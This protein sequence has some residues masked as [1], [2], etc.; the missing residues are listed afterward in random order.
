M[1]SAALK[2][3][4]PLIGVGLFILAAMVLYRQLKTYQLPDILRQVHAIPSGQIPSALLLMVISY[5]A[6]IGYDLPALRYI[7]H[8]LH[9]AKAAL[10]SLLGYAFSNSLGPTTKSAEIAVSGWAPIKECPASAAARV[11]FD[12]PSRDHLELTMG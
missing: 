6:M 1:K 11:F 10:A 2:R 8:Q 4:T 7:R 5:L 12:T 3:F 9:P